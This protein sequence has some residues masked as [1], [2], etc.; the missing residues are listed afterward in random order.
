MTAGRTVTA[1][2]FGYRAQ[3]RSVKGG[4]R[5]GILREME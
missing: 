1:P 3:R 4:R 2:G 5:V